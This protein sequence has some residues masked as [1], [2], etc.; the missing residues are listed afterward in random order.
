VLCGTFTPKVSLPVVAPPAQVE[1]RI[2]T[3]GQD[4]NHRSLP[5]TVYVL[6]QQLSWQLESTRDLEGGATLLSP[7]LIAAINGAPEVLCVG[8]ASFEGTTLTEEARAGERA[9]KMAQWVGMAIRNPHTRVITL[10][11][12]QYRGPADTESSQQRKAV[13]LITGPHDDQVDLSEALRSGLERIRQT[14]PVVD[15]LLDHYSRSNQW[16]KHLNA[17]DIKSGR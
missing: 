12:G 13:I 17:R 4:K 7:A 9:G 16:L 1:A 3:V 8:T 14:S 5:F 6:A 10:N 2:D 11:A 15:S